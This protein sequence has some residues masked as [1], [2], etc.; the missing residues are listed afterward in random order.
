M[1]AVLAFDAVVI[2]A[3]MGGLCAIDSTMVTMTCLLAGAGCKG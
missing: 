2:G 3:G 1:S